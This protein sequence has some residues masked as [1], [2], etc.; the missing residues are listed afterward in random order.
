MAGWTRQRQ[1]CAKPKWWVLVVLVW[2]TTGLE[3]AKE[4]ESTEPAEFSPL[5]LKRSGQER[6]AAKDIKRDRHCQALELIDRRLFLSYFGPQNEVQYF[7]V[8]L[9]P[10]PSQGLSTAREEAASHATIAHVWLKRRIH[11]AV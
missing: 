2:I 5:R 7:L 4:Q 3:Q 9:A 1:E 11:V 8:H 6:L 10:E